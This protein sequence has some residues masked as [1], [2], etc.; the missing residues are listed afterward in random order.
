[1]H[2][3]LGQVA[4]AGVEGQQAGGRNQVLER[5]Q[6]V[7]LLG[8]TEAVL[9]DGHHHAAG[10]VLV[11]LQHVDVPGGHLG[12]LVQPRRQRG[13]A[14]GRVQRRVVARGAGAVLGSG[15]GP[16]QVHRCVRQVADTFGGHH[17]ERRRAIVLHAAVVEAMRLDDPPCLVVG[18]RGQGT[19]VH[20]RPGIVLSMVIGGQ[21]YRFVGVAAD[22]GLVQV[23]HATHGEHLRRRH[24]P[25]GHR[26][27]G[28]ARDAREL[29]PLAEAGELA[30]GQ[31]PEHHHALSHAGGDSRRRGRHGSGSTAAAAAP[32]HA[33]E[34]QL[35]QAEGGGEPGGV[36]T[37][38]AVGGEPVDLAR[39]DAG[40][41]CR[42]QNGLQCQHEFRII[43]SAALVIA[44]FAHAGNGG[45]AAQRPLP[46]G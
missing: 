35:R 12:H 11:A 31:G 43:G 36:V 2:V 7:C 10:E 44:G 8:S 40:I 9:D 25:V 4:A 42:C 26:V 22:A 28:L 23:A 30:L 41:L 38:V 33:G 16:Q 32:L 19:A 21:G 18:L 46:G 45:A 1:M 24:Q 37:I 14:G 39:I 5:E 34:T 3:A 15:G 17:D 13:E 29:R 20:H 6:F 27:G